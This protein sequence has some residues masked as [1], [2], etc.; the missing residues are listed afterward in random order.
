M[1]VYISIP[2]KPYFKGFCH[3]VLMY[4]KSKL[5][6]PLKVIGNIKNTIPLWGRRQFNPTCI[7]R[8][9]LILTLGLG[10]ASALCNLL[11]MGFN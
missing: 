8:I 10:F 3:K 7:H 11:M 5:L 1:Y 6:K 2:L 4:I 9:S